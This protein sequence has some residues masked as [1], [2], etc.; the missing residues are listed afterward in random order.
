MDE[1]I[2]D[3]VQNNCEPLFSV[4][5]MDD[6]SYEPGSWEIVSPDVKHSADPW[7]Y[8]SMSDTRALPYAGRYTTYPGK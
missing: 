6:R 2:E 8:H 4:S 1:I 5:S 3:A 7:K